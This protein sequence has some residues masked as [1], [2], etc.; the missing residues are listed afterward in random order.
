MP[1]GEGCCVLARRHAHLVNCHDGEL[2]GLLLP[3]AVL[4][5]R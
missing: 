2:W 3:V 4:Q 5:C 1:Y